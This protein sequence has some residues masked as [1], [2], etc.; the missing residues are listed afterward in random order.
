MGIIPLVKDVKGKKISTVDF[1]YYWYNTQSSFSESI[2]TIRTGIVLESL[3]SPAKVIVITSTMPGEGKS[4]VALN[5]GSALGQMENVLVIGADLRRP[6]LASKLKM[7]GD[8]EGLSD[9]LGGEAKLGDCIHHNEEAN[10]YVLPA[11]KIPS[12][13]LEML[14]STKFKELLERLKTKFDRIVI[15]SA[16]THA[17]SDA[18]V[19]SS[20]ADT[21]VYVVKA[22]ETPA[23]LIRQGLRRLRESTDVSVGIVL[24]DFDE[25]KLSAYAGGGYYYDGY[26]SSR[27]S[28]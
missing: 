26:Y 13:P 15:D 7:Q 23:K 5:L 4:T 22:N 25:S 1:P 8:I 11:G 12:H 21:V 17:V 18:L 14:S 19:L 6:T 9:Y 27:K 20:N 16:P 2:R 28:G 10:C 3:D 24:N